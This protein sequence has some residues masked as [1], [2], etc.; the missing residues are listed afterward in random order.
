M[1]VAKSVPSHVQQEMSRDRWVRLMDQVERARQNVDET[2]CLR[3]AARETIEDS[4]QL[5]QEDT[6]VPD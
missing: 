4:R 5:R 3:E 2:R 6:H 1:H